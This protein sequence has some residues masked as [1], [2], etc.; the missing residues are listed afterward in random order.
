MVERRE[1]LR[2]ALETGEAIVIVANACGKTLI[3]TSR[4][5]LVSCAR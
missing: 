3:A 2:F 4:F 1:H 5:S